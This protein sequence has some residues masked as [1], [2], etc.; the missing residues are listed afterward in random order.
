[1]QPARQISA[2]RARSRAQ[3]NS[4]E[5]R[6][7]SE[8]PCEYPMIRAASRAFSRSASSTGRDIASPD[9]SRSTAR[10]RAASSDDHDRAPT[11]ASMVEADWPSFSASIT[12]QRPVP[13]WPATSRMASTTGPP[14]SGSSAA[15]TFA[16]MST[17]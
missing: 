6:A 15:S 8:N 14:V 11:A 9:G 12:V 2:M 16:V 13:F 3:P 5:A 1:M 17:R 10:A 4:A 7:R